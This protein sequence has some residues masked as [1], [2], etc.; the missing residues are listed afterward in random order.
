MTTPF[1]SDILD[2]ASGAYKFHVAGEWKVSASGKHVSI[3]NP[4]SGEAAFKVQGAS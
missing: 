4:T 2:S 3:G 1:Y